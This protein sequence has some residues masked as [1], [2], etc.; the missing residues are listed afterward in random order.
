MAVHSIVR[1]GPLLSSFG[2]LLA[3]VIGQKPGEALSVVTPSGTKQIRCEAITVTLMDEQQRPSMRMH[4]YGY[5][6]DDPH[7]AVT[8]FWNGGPGWSTALLHSGFAAPR[9]A[10]LANGTGMHDNPLTLVDRTDVIYVDPV[11]T[12]LTRAIKP[13]QQSDFW[14]V[15]DDAK[16][17]AQFVAR[18]IAERGWHQRP[19]YLCGESYGGIRVAAMLKP[20][21]D[22]GHVPEGLVMISPA[23]ECRSLAPRRGTDDR[24]IRRVDAVPTMA[25][26]L[27][28]SGKREVADLRED[29]DAVCAFATGRLV[30]AV[31]A[32]F[33]QEDDEP[34]DE[35]DAALRRTL[36]GFTDGKLLRRIRGRDRYDARLR[37]SVKGS[38]GVNRKALEDAIAGTLENTFGVATKSKYRLQAETRGLIWR[39]IG[40]KNLFSSDVRATRMIADACKDGGG[41]RVFIAGGWYDL[42]VRFATARRLKQEGAFG[43]SDVTVRDYP[44]GHMIYVDPQGHQELVRDLRNWFDLRPR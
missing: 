6:G 19:L 35:G 38:G 30:T 37:A 23:L 41:P 8:F 36:E 44:G 25:A 4:A 10:D 27:A 39:G 29:V 3:T 1:L 18:V 42:V 14:G 17:A 34:E 13:S 22:L 11:G 21:R 28:A 16:A 20:L 15:D 9:I 12:G 7:R 26:L 33:D 24:E 31:R 32:G 5:L 2:L 40:R 43:K